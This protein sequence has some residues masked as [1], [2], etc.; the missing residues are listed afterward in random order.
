MIRR[1]GLAWSLTVACG[2][3]A[4]IDDAPQTPCER[5]CARMAPCLATPSSCIPRCE[6]IPADC[7][8]DK[9]AFLDCA[10]AAAGPDCTFSQRCAEPVT[11]LLACA[12][13]GGIEDGDCSGTAGECYCAWSDASGAAS[14][15]AC[16]GLGC[17]CYDDDGFLGACSE[18]ASGACLDPAT[19]CCAQLQAIA[20]GNAP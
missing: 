18:S 10:I 15:Y 3:H 9:A 6:A 4:V 2:G 13:R 8:G 20:G 1:L 12:G 19:R 5:A 16:V 14:D 17:S 11:R 7:A